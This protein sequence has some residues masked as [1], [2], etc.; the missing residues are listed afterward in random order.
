MATPADKR[1]QM[2]RR[3]AEMSAHSAKPS[4]SD[5][6]RQSK[7]ERLRDDDG[8][9]GG[10]SCW[11]KLFS[12]LPK[13]R[14]PRGT[15]SFER[16]GSSAAAEDEE[17][18]IELAGSDTESSALS[19]DKTTREALDKNAKQLRDAER[20]EQMYQTRVEKF[21]NSA[22]GAKK[23]GNNK[24]ALEALRSKSHEQA[25]AT[26]AAGLVKQI[27]DA[28]NS[29]E[30]ISMARA[31]VDIKKSMAASMKAVMA[32]AGGVDA[33]VE[34]IHST[35]DDITQHTNEFARVND[36]LS[37]AG[38]L[39][40]ESR[41]DAMDEADLLAELEALDIGDAPALASRQPIPTPGAVVQMPA[42]FTPIRVASPMGSGERFP[43]PPLTTP[44]R[45]APRKAEL[46]SWN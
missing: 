18:E 41:G 37:A 20:M 28:R 44:P 38:T 22:I 25:L 16:L 8:D 27:I 7:R 19:V 36:V 10:R 35:S 4:K 46:A 14:E 21:H 43:P 9:A 39:D 32:N 11:A 30:G 31:A 15:Q 33:M 3:L 5:A 23:V 17:E 40:A 1:S 45:P 6:T 29:L 13:K 24:A 34:D 26:K 42:P 12:W 2:A